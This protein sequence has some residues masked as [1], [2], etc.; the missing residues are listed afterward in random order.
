MYTVQYICAVRNLVKIQY[1]SGDFCPL[2]YIL[3]IVRYVEE[4]LQL[5]TNF[6][7]ELIILHPYCQSWRE[8]MAKTFHAL[9]PL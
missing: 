8:Q 1:G 2:V 4:I 3:I 7:K 9:L 6:E 5:A